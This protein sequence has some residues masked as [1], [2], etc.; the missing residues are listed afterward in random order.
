[1]YN[2]IFNSRTS[3]ILNTTSKSHISRWSVSCSNI[4]K[5]SQCFNL[6]PTSYGWGST[7]FPDKRWFYVSEI[8]K[9][10]VN[11]NLAIQSQAV[12]TDV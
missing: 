7:V 4:D 3:Q 11:A 6:D 5:L 12:N 9:E 10:F 1:M 8:S 2:F